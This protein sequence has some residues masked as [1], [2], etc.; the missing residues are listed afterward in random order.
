MA[1]SSRKWVIM[2]NNNQW[3]WL[4]ITI[5]VWPVTSVQCPMYGECSVLR[6]VVQCIALHCRT[7]MKSTLLCIISLFTVYLFVII[8]FSKAFHYSHVCLTHSFVRSF[9]RLLVRSFIHAF[10]FQFQFQS[11]VHEISLMRWW[12]H[13]RNIMSNFRYF[14]NK[15]FPLERCL[16]SFCWQ[17]CVFVKF[18]DVF[19]FSFFFFCSCSVIFKELFWHTSWSGFFSLS[20]SFWMEN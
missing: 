10:S 7:A 6:F 2:N 20:I 18:I 14:V 4:R 9:H 13:L 3:P 16:R 17:V 8:M 11:N 5:N 15:L 19:R 1:I 12:Q